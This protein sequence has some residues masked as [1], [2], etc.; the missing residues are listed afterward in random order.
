M[1]NSSGTIVARY[2]YD[3]YGRTTLV[4]GSNLATKQYA[5]MYLHQT[6]GLNLTKYR[7]YDSSTGRWSSEDPEGE[8]GGINLYEYVA[9]DP[10]CNDDPLGLTLHAVTD[11]DIETEMLSICK[12]CAGVNSYHMPVSSMNWDQYADFM[13]NQTD[14][15][16][17]Y[18]SNRTDKYTYTGTE[19]PELLGKTFTGHELNYI[20]VGGGMACRGWSQGFSHTIDTIWDERNGEGY[21]SQNTFDATDA[22]YNFIKNGGCNKLKKGCSDPPIFSRR[23]DAQL[24]AAALP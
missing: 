11:K 13:A 14:T 18:G 23:S 21:P 5:G 6:S 20:G 3:P 9:N 8:D 12:R 4:S 2:A 19:F 24:P 17:H 22:G 10:V 16:Y 15:M 1:L 7:A